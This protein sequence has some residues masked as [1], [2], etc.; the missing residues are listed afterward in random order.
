[1]IT[2]IFPI[3]VY[4]TTVKNKINKK[5][6]SK[7]KIRKNE[8][9]S[10]TNY[11]NVL[12]DFPKLKKEIERHL[13]DYLKM[14]YNP[15]TNVKVYITESWLNFT[16]KGE[17]HHRHNHPNSFISGVYYVSA[18]EELDRINFLN[19]RK[20]ALEIVPK[21]YNDWNCT[22]YYFG[23]KSQ[24]IILFPSSLEHFVNPVESTKTRISLAFNSFLKGE[25]GSTNNATYLK[26]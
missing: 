1:M 24:D 8:F 4:K 6:M 5:D 19:D 17:T 18:D 16:E 23:I 3:P 13:N 2:N 21:Q 9:N 26:L 25:L 11:K 10:I 14:V 15:S 7:Y 20:G 12:K 22:S